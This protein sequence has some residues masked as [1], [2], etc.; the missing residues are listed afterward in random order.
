MDGWKEV[1][2]S[3]GQRGED[4]GGDESAGRVGW[5]EVSVEGLRC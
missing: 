1:S 5:V 3:V 2:L 4:K